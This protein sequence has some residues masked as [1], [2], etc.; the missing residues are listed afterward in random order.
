MSLVLGPTGATGYPGR[1]GVQGATGVFRTGQLS[2][3]FTAAEKTVNY[4]YQLYVMLAF[5]TAKIK[6]K[7]QI[8]YN[9]GN[10]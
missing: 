1:P 4:Y 5:S 8:D 9:N 3:P 2:T 7:V 6:K 10:V